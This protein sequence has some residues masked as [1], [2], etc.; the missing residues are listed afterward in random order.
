MKSRTTLGVSFFL[1]AVSACSNKPPAEDPS[2]AQE[3][4]PPLAPAEFDTSGLFVEGIAGGVMK[5][6]LS[7]EAE[8]LSVD[9][10][11]RQAVLRGPEGN[12]WTVRVGKDAVNFY[13]VAPGDR[14]KVEMMRELMVY[15]NEDGKEDDTSDGTVAMAAGTEKGQKPEGVIVATSQ[16]TSQIS[17]INLEARTATLLFSDGKEETFEVR[18]D[19]DMT[20]YKVGQEVVF[21]LTEMLA[22]KVEKL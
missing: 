21:L 15:V 19:V 18:P 17:A 16:I 3:E 11:K 9:Q 4:S 5:A 14:V 13:Q 1:L 10:E 20:R 12:E 6:T 7:L 8:V 2:S 22:L